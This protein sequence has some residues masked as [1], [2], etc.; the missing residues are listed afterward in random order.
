MLTSVLVASIALF[1]LSAS[2]YL[3]FLTSEPLESVGAR[4][5]R[6]LK[7]PEAVMAST[8][9]ALATSGPEIIMAIIAATPFILSDAWSV[10]QVSERASAGALN[11]S[12]SAM[13]N[14]LGIGAVGIVYM[15]WKGYLNKDDVVEVAPSVKTSLVFYLVASLCFSYFITNGVLTF[16]ESWILMGI[17]ITY[18]VSQFFLPNLINKYYPYDGGG[19]DEEDGDDEPMPTTVTAWFSDTGKNTFLYFALVWAMVLFVRECLGATF[20]FATIGI[21]SVGGILIMF[22]SYVSSFPEFMLTYRYAS[23]NNKDAL[24]GM[25]FGSNVIDLA[26]AGFRPIWLKEDMNVM[27]TGMAN[28]LLPAY[29]WSLPILATLMIVLMYFRILKFRHA[30]PMIVLYVL[31]IVSGFILL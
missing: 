28:Y 13:D 9:G 1:V 24:L 27:T 22:T 10:L 17:G 21:V 20:D 5:G 14:L 4:L 16:T 26:F 8:L 19:D 30:K 29:I 11:M 12:F 2:C 31:Y 25:L 7:M 23:S 6:L 3:L 18:V 15:L